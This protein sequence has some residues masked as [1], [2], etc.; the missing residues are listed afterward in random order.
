MQQRLISTFK[1]IKMVVTIGADITVQNLRFR[2]TLADHTLRDFGIVGLFFFIC[3]AV[4][5][6]GLMRIGR[7]NTKIFGPDR[8]LA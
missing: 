7:K 4:H 3:L 6:N 5:A 1:R 8:L 2:H